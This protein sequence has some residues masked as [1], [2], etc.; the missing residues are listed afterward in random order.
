MKNKLPV[1][2]REAA[3]KTKGDRTDYEIDPVAMRA[4]CEDALETWQPA[5]G[6][7]FLARFLGLK[8]CYSDEQCTIEF[9]VAPFMLNP[10]GTLHGG[11]VALVLDTAMGHLLAHLFGGGST[12]EMKVQYLRAVVPG[13]ARVVAK[14]IRGGHSICFFEASLYD[15]NGEIAAFA[16]ST[17]KLFSDKQII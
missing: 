3:G 5:M 10:K 6:A 14:V 17:W 13:P 16:T 2:M 12:L 11:I 8:F 7:F 9:D 1:T 15:S 4:I